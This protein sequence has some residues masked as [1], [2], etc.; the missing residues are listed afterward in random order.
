MTAPAH[1]D[2]SRL[3]PR[4]LAI[5]LYTRRS[6]FPPKRWFAVA[7]PCLGALFSMILWLIFF[8]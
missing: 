3:T 4:L 2:G 6:C 1:T 7:L 8:P 5:L